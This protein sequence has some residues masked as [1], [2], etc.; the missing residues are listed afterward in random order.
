MN[1]KN[2]TVVAHVKAQPGKENQLRQELLSL[3]GPSRKDEGCLNYDLH[4]GAE[5]PALFYF[6]ETW[7]SK[8]LWNRHM[9][10]PEL[11]ATLARAAQ[12]VAE[13]P[14]ITLWDKIS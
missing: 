7:V 1:A 5:D 13:L 9:Q 4:Q 6:H 14:K 8:E 11:Q 10:K 2:L 12:L 3:V